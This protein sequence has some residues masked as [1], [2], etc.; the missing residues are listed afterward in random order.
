MNWVTEITH[1]K[2]KKYF[3]DEQER[4]HIKCAFMAHIDRN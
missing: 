4:D 1:I 2:D 3:V